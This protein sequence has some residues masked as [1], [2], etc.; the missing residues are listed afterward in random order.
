MPTAR[1]QSATLLRFLMDS[2]LIAMSAK[3]FEFHPP[4]CV[5]AVFSGGV[6]GH[7]SGSLGWITATFGAFQ[8]D[9]NTNTFSSHNFKSI[10]S[11]IEKLN[12][13]AYFRIYLLV[14]ASSFFSFKSRE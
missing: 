11:K 13:N 3:L 12:T 5:P 6:A 4:G 7:P 8:R 2:V 1:M 9:D 10:S 14:C